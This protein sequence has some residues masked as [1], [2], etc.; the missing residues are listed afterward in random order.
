[1]TVRHDSGKF[2]ENL[3]KTGKYLEAVSSSSS[4]TTNFFFLFGFSFTTIHDSQDSRGSG[5]LF[6]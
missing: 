6:L 1:M 5:R 3:F 2:V 4:Q